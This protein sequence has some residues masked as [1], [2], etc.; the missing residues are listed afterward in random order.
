MW[1]EQGLYKLLGAALAEVREDAEL[2]QQE[3]A[4]RLRKPQSFVSSYETGQRRLDVLE[5][6]HIATAMGLDPTKTFGTLMARLKSARG[7]R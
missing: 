1:L 7:K 3:L 6:V 5:F 2:T 4:R